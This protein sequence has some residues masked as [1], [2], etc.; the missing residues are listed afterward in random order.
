MSEWIKME[1][2]TPPVDRPVLGWNK[3][4]NAM[5]YANTYRVFWYISENTQDIT[6]WHPDEIPQPPTE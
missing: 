1:D 6:H 3:T 2:E 5:N 4:R